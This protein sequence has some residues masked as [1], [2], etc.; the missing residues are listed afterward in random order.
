[1]F[2][3]NWGGS[4]G[5]STGTYTGGFKGVPTGVATDD[6]D[7]GD[8]QPIG[9]INS[10]R[11]LKAHSAFTDTRVHSI[12]GTTSTGSKDN[13]SGPSRDTAR[14]GERDES[15]GL[16]PGAKWMKENPSGQRI[17]S[18]G[19]F[20]QSAAHTATGPAHV[21]W[22]RVEVSSESASTT[23]NSNHSKGSCDESRHR[24]NI[25]NIEFRSCSTDRDKISSSSNFMVEDGVGMMQLR[26]ANSGASFGGE[27]T[28]DLTQQEIRVLTPLDLEVLKQHPDIPLDRHGNPT[29]IGSIVHHSGT[30]KPCAFVHTCMCTS[31]IQC[32][33]CHF[34]HKR[35]KHPR[36]SKKKRERYQNIINRCNTE[37]D[38]PAACASGL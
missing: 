37:Q 26:P 35:G 29:S 25:D 1:M 22:G 23:S 11:T 19:G 9:A 28:E 6:E 30:C 2:R 18:K 36:P 16:Q 3:S 12:H 15:S 24:K 31:G 14:I 8:D 21:I 34:P 32:E 27:E 10:I 7:V 20:G 17:S 33:F 4:T 5:G 38:G 13:L